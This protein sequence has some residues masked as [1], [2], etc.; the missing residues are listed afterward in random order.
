MKPLPIVPPPSEAEKTWRSIARGFADEI[1]RPSALADEEAHRFRRDFFEEAAKRGLASIAFPPEYGGR[2]QAFV[3]F[4]A[5]MEEV[6]RASMSMA[7]TLGVTTLVEGAIL[8]YGD[9][10]QKDRFLR[11]LLAGKMIGAFSLS[12]PHSGSDAA[13]L[14]CAAKKVDGGYR[15][16]GTKCWVSTAGHAD[17]YLL[18]ARTGEPKSK[19][20]TS[21]LVPKETK[22]LHVGKQE[23]KLGLKASPLAELI[24]EDAFVPDE[25]R[26]GE[27]GEGLA[28]ALSQLDA[29]RVTIGAGGVGIAAE[30]VEHAWRF[31][32]AREKEFGVPFEPIAQQ[33][34]AQLYTEVQSARALVQAAGQS[35]DRK[36]NF[37]LIAAQAKM[38]GS[39]VS[40]RVAS[41]V[42]T[43]CGEGAIAME[44]GLERLLRDSRA[45]PIVEGTNQIQKLV[46][47][48]E[49]ENVLG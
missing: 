2:G 36:E 32:R 8:Q 43:W 29:G 38:W 3:C 34:L 44:A 10:A 27:E 11:P 15:I 9:D 4:Y 20:I 22:G 28:V 49:M 12:E 17:V 13:A 48:R 16:T 46:I 45:L 14:R 19:G 41:E 5:A 40:V 25:L 21:F 42:L 47:A 26:L 30:A 7:V 33:A 23:K 31:M 24:F 39:D 37:T 1:L 6:A 18:M 35:R